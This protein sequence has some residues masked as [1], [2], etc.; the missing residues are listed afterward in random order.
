VKLSVTE[1]V[2]TVHGIIFFQTR[3]TNPVKNVKDFFRISINLVVNPIRR[4]SK[5]TATFA[6]VF[7]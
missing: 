6:F 5:A 7:K 1:I 2:R 3:K 4:T